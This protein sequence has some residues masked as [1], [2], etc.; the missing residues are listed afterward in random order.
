LDRSNGKDFILK[1]AQLVAFVPPKL[2][3]KRFAGVGKSLKEK[4]LSLQRTANH[5]KWLALP[6][7]LK[8]ILLAA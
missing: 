8:L 3:F 2:L 6:F 5:P 7:S 4:Q 1:S